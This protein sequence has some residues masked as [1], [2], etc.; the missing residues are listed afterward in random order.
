MRATSFQRSDE[1]VTIP[2]DRGRRKPEGDT[3]PENFSR[4]SREHLNIDSMTEAPGGTF[5]D[6][7]W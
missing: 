6:P 3:S 1:P 5:Q 7:E 2:R 4:P